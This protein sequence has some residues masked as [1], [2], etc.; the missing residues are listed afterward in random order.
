MPRP[1]QCVAG[2][3]C[4]PPAL[5]PAMLAL[6]PGA[7]AQAHCVRAGTWFGA[8][9]NEG[10]AFSFGASH[11]PLCRPEPPSLP[12]CSMPARRAVS[13]TVTPSFDF[14]DFEMATRAT[15]AADLGEHALAALGEHA[16]AL[17]PE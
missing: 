13:C 17:V 10:S 12:A 5:A 2:V 7:R 1:R 4:P 9:P 8:F 15:L 11:A 3:G 14:R 16:P 6:R